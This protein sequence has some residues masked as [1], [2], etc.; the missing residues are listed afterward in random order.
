M[1]KAGKKNYPPELVEYITEHAGE[2]TLPWM[3]DQVREL[4][5]IDMTY[6]AIKGFYANRKLHAKKIKGRQGPKGQR[7]FP[8]HV[9]EYIRDNYKGKGPTEMSQEIAK[10]FGIE[11]TPQQMKIYYH[12]QGYNSGMTGRF[13]KG[14][15]SHNK[16]KKASPETVERIRQSGTMFQK[17]QR[18]KNTK[19]IGAESKIDGYWKVKVAEPNKWQLKSRYEWERLHGEKL[20]RDDVIVFLDG[21][22]DNFKPE[23]L[24]KI[25]RAELCRYNK[26]G[27]R[28][29]D[30]E[31]NAAAVA[32]AKLQTVAGKRR[33]KNGK[34]NN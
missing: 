5:G 24:A 20:G 7:T 16:G 23:N 33:K 26:N 25:S 13:V 4:F 19:P 6:G 30:P 11:K 12:N 3:Q 9:A 1:G 32:L 15:Q 34:D 17:G 18:P 8:L 28:T 21:N 14:Q 29:P 27:L 2:G 22:P 31:V 10:V